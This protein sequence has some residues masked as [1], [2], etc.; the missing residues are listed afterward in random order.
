VK[1]GLILAAAVGALSVATA[2]PALAF[3]TAGAA[4]SFTISPR[5]GTLGL[6][7]A[8]SATR[9]KLGGGNFDSTFT[10][11]G[12]P[13]P[14]TIAGEG[15]KVVE[16]VSSGGQSCTILLNAGSS[17]VINNSAPGTK[18]YKITTFAGT[19]W[20]GPSS[21]VCLFSNNDTTADCSATSTP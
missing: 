19:N 11:T 14:G 18:T 21:R 16:L 10:I 2:T 3:W 4:G 8:V 12:A 6:A 7:G 15:Y 1:R 5:A 17:C 20:V 13:A 9:V